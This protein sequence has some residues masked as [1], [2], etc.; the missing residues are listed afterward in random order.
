[1]SALSSSQPFP[2]KFDTFIRFIA[3][4][5]INA[6]IEKLYRF[7][8]SAT[9]VS[10]QFLPSTII[11]T[12][13]SE[14]TRPGWSAYRT[15]SHPNC[16]PECTAFSCNGYPMFMCQFWWWIMWNHFKM[17]FCIWGSNDVMW[18]S[19]MG[20]DWNHPTKRSMKVERAE[21]SKIW[22]SF[23]RIEEAYTTNFFAVTLAAF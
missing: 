2:L 15:R 13:K 3:L 9:Q 8:S 18:L 21:Q 17:V 22:P 14:W 19:D 4:S 12:Q 1:M 16:R 11:W 6:W 5:W 7:K 23:S 20:C 10:N